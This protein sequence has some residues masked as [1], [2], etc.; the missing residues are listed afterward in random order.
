MADLVDRLALVLGEHMHDDD[1]LHVTY[2]AMQ[3]GWTNHPPTKGHLI[4]PP[5]Q[6]GT[7]LHSNTARSS[8]YAPAT[9]PP[10]RA[11]GRS[12][13]RAVWRF[14]ARER[15]RFAAALYR[16]LGGGFGA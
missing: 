3:A 7:E 14:P 6:G 10:D 5:Q 12:C 16:R 9:N 4:R 11:E 1:E 8:S 2:N 13:S 15:A